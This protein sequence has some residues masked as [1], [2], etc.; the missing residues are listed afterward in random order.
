MPD[1]SNLLIPEDYFLDYAK[2]NSVNS[3]PQINKFTVQLMHRETKR[4]V[5]G[6]G[7]SIEIA[8]DRAVKFI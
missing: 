7:E 6:Y 2:E 4:F 8:L 3:W 1:S 5:R